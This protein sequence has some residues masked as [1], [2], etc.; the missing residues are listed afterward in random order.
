MV[1]VEAAL[2]IATLLVATM[3]ASVVPSSVAAQIRCTDAAREVALLLA[4]DAPASQVNR[5]LAVLAPQKAELSVSTSDGWVTVRVTSRAPTQGPLAGKLSL[6]VSGS[7]VARLE[8][9]RRG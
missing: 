1:T 6:S 5:A 7:A 2:A 9:S 4:R 8:S 3:L